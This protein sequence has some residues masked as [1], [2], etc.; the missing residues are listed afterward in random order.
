MRDT[1]YVM[2]ASYD[3]VDDALAAY[4]AIEGTWRHFSGS[5]DFDATVVAKDEAGKVE[6]V[7]RHDE[8]TRHGSRPGSTGA[9]PWVSSQRCFP[10]W[11]SWARSPSAPGP[12]R[13]WERWP[14]TPT[15]R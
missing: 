3:D 15:D 9:S 6:I 4:Q 7:R 5:H 10:P 1:L 12:A 13:R 11:G 8:P 14:A 2:A